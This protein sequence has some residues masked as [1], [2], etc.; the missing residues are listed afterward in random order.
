MKKLAV[1]SAVFFSGLAV[2]QTQVP[3][4]FE[5]GTP[6]SATEVNA[7][8]DTLESAINSNY[9]DFE[10][11]RADTQLLLP[12]SNCSTDQ[13]IKWNGSKWVCSDPSGAAGPQGEKGDTGDTGPQGPPGRRVREEQL[14]PKVFKAFRAIREIQVRRVRLAP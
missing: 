14:A 10:L 5:D 1:L 12:P 13:I 8:F 9:E 2:A 3:N 11:F 6:A 4:V 7:N